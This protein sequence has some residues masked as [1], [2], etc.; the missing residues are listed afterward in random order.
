MKIALNVESIDPSSGG[1]ERYVYNLATY[2]IKNGHEVHIISK[3]SFPLSGGHFHPAGRIWWSKLADMI[4]FAL[5]SKAILGKNEFDIIHG[6][7][8]TLYQDVYRI[9]GGCHHIYYLQSIKALRPGFLRWFRAMERRIRPRNLLT[10]YIEKRLYRRRRYQKIVAV[11][12]WVQT[13]LW[14]Q[15]MIPSEDIPVI[16]NGVDLERFHPRHKEAHGRELREKLGLKDTR[17]FLFVSN[18]YL[19][20]GLSF[21]IQALGI[22]NASRSEMPVALLVVGKDRPGPFKKLA[23]ALGVGKQTFFIGAIREGLDHWYGAADCL[24]HPTLYDPF[25]NVCLE[26]LASGLPVITSR[27]NGASEIIKEGVEGRIITDPTSPDEIASRME[28]FIDDDLL[29]KY[30]RRARALAE[31]YSLD[32][33]LNAVMEVYNGVLQQKRKNTG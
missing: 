14:D 15:Y 19:L 26:A 8:R 27:F 6:F 18:N 1:V 4:W 17:V 33:N 31:S 9:G 16:Y 22:L 25:S 30:S 29:H 13:Q 32:R 24:V 23:R 28:T 21:L 11:S 10:R 20:K 7:G 3:S 5:A 12:R 2:L